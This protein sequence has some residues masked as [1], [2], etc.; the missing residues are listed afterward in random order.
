M[1]ILIPSYEPDQRLVELVS[2]LKSEMPYARVLVVDDGSGAAYHAIFATVAKGGAH[3][4]HHRS[5]RGKGVALRTGIGWL[6]HNAPGHDVVCADSDGQHR[7]ADIARVASDVETASSTGDR[8]VILGS[9]AFVGQVPLR[10]RFGNRF[11]SMMFAVATGRGLSDTQTGLRGYSSAVL[12]WLPTVKGQR[13]EYELNLLLDA[14]RRGIALREV[15]IETI[16]LEENASSHFRPLIDS[17]RVIAPLLA[18]AAS[19]LLAFAVDAIALIA[20][21]AMTGNLLVSAAAARVLS[22]SVNYRINRSTVFRSGGGVRQAL[23]YIA[24]AGA[25][26]GAGY[27]GLRL[28]TQAGLPLLAAKVIT[29]VV[30][31]VVSF[32]VQREFVFTARSRGREHGHHKVRASGEGAQV[33]RAEAQLFDQP[34]GSDIS[35]QGFDLVPPAQAKAQ[36]EA[37]TGSE[38]APERAQRLHVRPLR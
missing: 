26:L 8:A 24:L 27:L 5:N 21:S 17:V 33:P 22:A 23:H 6:L 10:S 4:L 32:V 14:Q 3:V 9:R 38:V 12:P 13:F 35:L 30:L 34:S 31:Y 7:A 19:S 20:L 18:F 25:L 36:H 11:S 29:D 15:A 16:Y 2:H 1:W 37:A 28:L